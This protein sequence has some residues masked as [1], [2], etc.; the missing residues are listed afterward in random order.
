MNKFLVPAL[1]I[2]LVGVAAAIGASSAPGVAAPCVKKSAECG[3]MKGDCDE[4]KGDCS[5]KLDL[6]CVESGQGPAGCPI[7]AAEAAKVAAAAAAAA[8]QECEGEPQSDCCKK[9]SQCGEA[10]KTVEPTEKP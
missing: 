6:G 9:K 8:A 3:Q 10:A 5:S 7:A 4:M 2:G 1:L